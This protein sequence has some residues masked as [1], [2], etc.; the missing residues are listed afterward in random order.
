MV[1]S[2]LFNKISPPWSKGQYSGQKSL[3]W[4]K[5]SAKAIFKKSEYLPYPSL[6]NIYSMQNSWRLTSHCI[7]EMFQL[8]ITILFQLFGSTDIGGYDPYP[9]VRSFVCPELFSKTAHRILTKR[10]IFWE[11]LW[12]YNT[13]CAL[14]GKKVQNKNDILNSRKNRTCIPFKFRGPHS[15]FYFKIFIFLSLCKKIVS[16]TRILTSQYQWLRDF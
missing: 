1:W 16:M 3:F 8:F 5:I 13:D 4:E 11:Y 15:T 10:G 12:K 2:K 6:S 7:L 9:S 14:F